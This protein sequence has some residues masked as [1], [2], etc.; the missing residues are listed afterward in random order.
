VKAE[1]ISYIFIDERC[2]EGR[3]LT[4]PRR[5]SKYVFSNAQHGDGTSGEFR[6]CKHSLMLFLSLW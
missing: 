2:L 5:H 6:S 3:A 4:I 1:S